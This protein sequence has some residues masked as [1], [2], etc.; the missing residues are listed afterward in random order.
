MCRF[1]V[2]VSYPIRRLTLCLQ[3]LKLKGFSAYLL[4]WPT[5]GWS[6]HP[7]GGI[8]ES[9]P[10][11]LDKNWASRFGGGGLAGAA[12]AVLRGGQQ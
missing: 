7:A 3:D 10:E 4:K 5:K 11:L 9:F 2:S 1:I 8:P 12:G 6:G